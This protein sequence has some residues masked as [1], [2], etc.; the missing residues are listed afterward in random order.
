MQSFVQ[1]PFDYFSAPQVKARI[2]R[3]GGK[4]TLCIKFSHV[5]ADGAA[6]KEGAYLLADIYQRLGQDPSWRPRPNISGSRSARQISQRLT[7]ADKLK[8][9]R[10]DFRNFAK[11]R[12]CWKRFPASGEETPR[13]VREVI[14]PRRFQA[15]K[16]NGREKGATI[17]DLL[18]AAYYRALHR[19]LGPMPGRAMG[20]MATADLRRYL[21]EGR[22]GGLCNLSG[23]VF[24]NIGREIGAEFKDTLALVVEDIGF[25]KKDYLGLGDHPA[26]VFFMNALPYSIG[27]KAMESIFMAAMGFGQYKGVFTN[28]GVIDEG[29]FDLGGPEVLD[30]YVQVPVTKK[31]DTALIIGTTTFKNKITL[32]SGFMG[33]K[34]DHAHVERILRA[35]SEELPHDS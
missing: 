32:A 28:L 23:F 18:I 17:N 6:A 26:L 24:S 14:G 3:S 1:E 31:L 11:K 4:D 33:S 19:E 9:I 5:P 12:G 30:A 22:A 21:P 27:L 13:F 10:R 8:V 16:N 25:Q 15:I 35:V 20:I 34:E 2:V 29:L 7:L